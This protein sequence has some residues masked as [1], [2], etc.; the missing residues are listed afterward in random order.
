M[1]LL[2]ILTF[3]SLKSQNDIIP[4]EFETDCRALDSSKYSYIYNKFHGKYDFI[5]SH[6]YNGGLASV[7]DPISIYIQD[8]TVYYKKNIL[9]QGFRENFKDSLMSSEEISCDTLTQL[10][11]DIINHGF[12]SFATDSLSYNDGSMISDCILYVYELMDK[13]NYKKIQ[14]YCPTFY[15]RKSSRTKEFVEFDKYYRDNYH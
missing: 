1:L 10:L 9:S 4:F 13:N 11:T 2:Y 15:R 12:L 5:L 7:G 3:G 8:S 14:T 6:Y